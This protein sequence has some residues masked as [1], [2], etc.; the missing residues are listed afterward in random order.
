MKLHHPNRSLAVDD[1]PVVLT[2]EMAEWTYS[3]L[4]TIRVGSGERRTIDTGG[5]EFAILP[6]STSSSPSLPR[7][8]DFTLTAGPTCSNA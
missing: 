4:R 7:E 2:P 3:G 5:E 1:D 6:L 8:P